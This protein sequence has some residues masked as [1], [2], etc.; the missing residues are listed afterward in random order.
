MHQAL[1]FPL[2]ERL[3]YH[4]RSAHAV[5]YAQEAHTDEFDIEEIKSINYMFYATGLVAMYKLLMVSHLC[6]SRFCKAAYV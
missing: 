4:H 5:P 3:F 1:P 2:L 6:F